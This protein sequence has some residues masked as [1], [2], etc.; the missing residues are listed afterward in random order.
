MITI[1]KSKLKDII[2][3]VQLIKVQVDHLKQTKLL[4]Q[5]RQQDFILNCCKIMALMKERQKE[6]VLEQIILMDEGVR[7][8]TTDIQAFK[9][10]RTQL[11]QKELESKG[12]KKADGKSG[13]AAGPKDVSAVDHNKYFLIFF[14]LFESIINNT[15]KLVD[16]Y[17]DHLIQQCPKDVARVCAKGSS[18][19]ESSR[20]K[21]E[22]TGEPQQSGEGAAEGSKAKDGKK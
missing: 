20:S 8:I 12:D 6:F 21:S 2:Q 11:F 13:K 17:S 10:I 3:Q 7:A 14:H 22:S 18:G 15:S 4:E 16:Q 19:Q 9:N 1:H 5:Q